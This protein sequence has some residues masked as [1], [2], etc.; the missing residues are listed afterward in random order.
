MLSNSLREE[1]MLAQTIRKDASLILARR[2]FVRN[3]I[4]GFLIPDLVAQ[5]VH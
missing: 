5:I 1:L 3:R 2:I 4:R